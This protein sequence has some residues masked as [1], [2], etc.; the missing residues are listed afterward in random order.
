MKEPNVHV[1]PHSEGGWSVMREGDE[2][3][4]RVFDT[5]E[6]AV[7]FGKNLARVNMVEYIE[8]NHDGRIA[9]RNSYGNDPY[10][11]AG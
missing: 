10:P 4:S 6:E 8:H 1:T 3:A 7:E 9:E 5:K 2:R 11:P